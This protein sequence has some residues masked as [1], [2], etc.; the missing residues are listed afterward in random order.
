M[1]LW[2]YL[3]KHLENIKLITK[4]YKYL[5]NPLEC[6][7]IFCGKL[8]QGNKTENPKLTNPHNLKA[9]LHT[10]FSAELRKN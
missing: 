8:G 10:E 2:G 6:S 3:H 5:K 4:N 1:Y 9:K 7:R